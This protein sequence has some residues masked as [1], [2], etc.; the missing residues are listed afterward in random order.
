MK[1]PLLCTA[2]PDFRVLKIEGVTFEKEGKKV[3]IKVPFFFCNS[4]ESRE[5]LGSLEYFEGIAEK[6]YQEIKK[7]EFT[8]VEFKYENKSFHQ[9][10]HLGLKYSSE[11]YYLI[12]GLSREW[13][14]G[15][16]TPVF[17][18]KDLLLYYNH[19]PN[20]SVKLYSF[21]S[22]NIYHH[23]EPMLRYGF[24]INRSGKIFTWLGD[25]DEDLGDQEML[26]DLKRFQASNIDSDHDI[27]SKFYLSQIPF[28]SSDMFQRS[29]NEYKVFSLKDELRKKIFDL[30]GITIT[31]IEIDDLSDYYKPPILEEKEQIFSSYLGLNKYLIENIQI[32]PLK[33]ALIN[34][35]KKK[36][37]ISQLGSLKTFEWY[38]SEV[39]KVPNVK[40]IIS[41]LY[42]LN[43]L[44]QLHGHLSKESFAEKYDSCKERLELNK[45]SNH[46][47]V[48]K[49]L[50]EKLIAFY[51]LALSNMNG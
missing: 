20:Y 41:P 17:F 21:S 9:Y 50:I 10:D 29:D 32:T 26:S 42:V 5:P 27:F 15:F 48:Y 19:H 28:V 38:L 34:A 3:G 51:Q 8:T 31:L 35:G 1:N 39:L 33:E 45:D 14:D 47:E 25:I 30:H 18:D 2:C 16:L 7:G 6:H 37:D 24:G 22:G 43:D 36:E 40:S 11:D 46:F 49:K 13:D 4:C 44:R 23:D 12:P